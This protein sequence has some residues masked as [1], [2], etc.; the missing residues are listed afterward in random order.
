MS[1]MSSNMK[2]SEVS[3]YHDTMPF[4]IILKELSNEEKIKIAGI[5][6]FMLK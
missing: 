5:E 2:I 4:Q 3:S 6:I 1:Q